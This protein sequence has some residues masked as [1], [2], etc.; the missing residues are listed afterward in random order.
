[1]IKSFKGNPDFQQN[2]GRRATKVDGILVG[3]TAM[4][5]QVERFVASVLPFV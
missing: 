2:C 3:M 4:A 1:M 5:K